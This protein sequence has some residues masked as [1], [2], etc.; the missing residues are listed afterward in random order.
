MAKDFFYWGDAH[1]LVE[2]VSKQLLSEHIVKWRAANQTCPEIH[3][4]AVRLC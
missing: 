3:P 1:F 4:A 2:T